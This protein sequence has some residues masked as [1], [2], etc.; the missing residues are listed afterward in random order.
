MCYCGCKYEYYPLGPNE[1][2]HC[3]R[4][5]NDCPMDAKD[6]DDQEVPAREDQEYEYEDRLCDDE[7]VKYSDAN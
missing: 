1:D 5:R 6:E 3:R 4:G 2:C 7:G